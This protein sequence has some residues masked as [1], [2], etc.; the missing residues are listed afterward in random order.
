MYRNAVRYKDGSWLAPGSHAFELYHSKDPKARQELDKHIKKLDADER[1]LL[2][3]GKSVENA[4]VAKTLQPHQQRV[5]EEKKENDDR[6][7]KLV[8]FIESNPAFNTVL[9][10]AE[11]NR[12]RRQRKI[13]EDLSAVLGERISAFNTES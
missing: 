9:I 7:V 5:V 6:L 10:E 8:A 3:K 11:R 2:T 1:I 4:T 12:L 13:M